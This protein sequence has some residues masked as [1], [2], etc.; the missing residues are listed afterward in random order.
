[1]HETCSRDFLLMA[2]LINTSWSR[3]GEKPWLEIDVPGLASFSL[4]FS[5]LVHLN[6]LACRVCNL[7]SF[8]QMTETMV[9][10]S[11]PF[12]LLQYSVSSIC[13]SG[14]HEYQLLYL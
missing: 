13:V 5:A 3:E 1:M 9:D 12:V 4:L 2:L 10:V 14:E 6:M 11:E 8:H 7:F